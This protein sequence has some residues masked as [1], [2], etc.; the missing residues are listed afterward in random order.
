MCHGNMR[1]NWLG[2]VRYQVPPSGHKI[3]GNKIR[4]LRRRKLWEDKR[5]LLEAIKLYN[6]QVPDEECIAE[7]KVVSGLS[8]ERDSGAD[9][10]IWPWEVH[11]SESS[12]ILTKKKIY[13]AYMSKVRLQE[14]RIIVMREMRQHCTY[15]RKLAG[16]I[17]TMKSEMSSGRN[18]GY[19][20]PPKRKEQPQS[21]NTN[22]MSH[23]PKRK[24]QPQSPNTNVNLPL[25][26]EQPIAREIQ[27]DS[28]KS[29][30]P[31]TSEDGT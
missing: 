14:E 31:E 1:T 25:R 27:D 13:D 9:S 7:E 18:S 12:N 15:L 10:L 24:E 30:S 6:E 5:K 4:H 19:V 23:L 21:P 22:D 20:T 2:P 29:H 26:T 11:S 8:V 17:R 3:A 28:P 16:N